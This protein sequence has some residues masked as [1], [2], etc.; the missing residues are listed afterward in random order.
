[1]I[2]ENATP[3]AGPEALP[4]AMAPEPEAEEAVPT[5]TVNPG[6][7]AAVHD[8]VEDASPTGDSAEISAVHGESGKLTSTEKKRTHPRSVH[9]S[10][11]FA[12]SLRVTHG[13]MGCRR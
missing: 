3:E 2:Q 8:A 4:A 1:M 11:I 5:G 9:N 13:V 6:A 10:I 12:S 7:T